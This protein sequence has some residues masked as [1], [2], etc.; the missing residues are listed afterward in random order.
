MAITTVTGDKHLLN[1]TANGFTT[2][3]DPF[4]I[5]VW[6][7]GTWNA[8][9]ASM[10]GVYGP[11]GTPT[12]AVQIGS[13]GD[14]RVSCWTWGGAILVSSVGTVVNGVWNHI[15][16]TYDGTSHRLYVN[17]QLSNT[18]TTAPVA[19]QLAYVYVNGYPTGLANE[20][21]VYSVDSYAYYN[22]TLTPEE[23]LTQYSLQGARHGV[24]NGLVASY[25]FDELA[26]GSTVI[27]ITDLSG[28]EN[29]LTV[30][31]AGVRNITHTY[32][33]TVASSNL[34]MV[35]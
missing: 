20:T 26:E 24:V 17:G 16:Y 8:A 21:A 1:A 27:Q 2:T 31:G 11:V 7:N 30:A 32:T 25:E 12:S 15:V 33:G 9:V 18:T 10:V 4:S 6:I 35:Q 23:V 29:H 19:A 28:N 34:K 5:S 22:Y 3:V 13:I 14:G